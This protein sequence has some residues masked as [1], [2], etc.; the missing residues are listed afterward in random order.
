MWR[1]TVGRH[2]IRYTVR[3]LP[4]LY[5]GGLSKLTIV[6]RLWGGRRGAYWVSHAYGL[7]LLTH[8]IIAY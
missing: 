2:H 8:E 4:S 5:I 3:A 7:F 6:P 1:L